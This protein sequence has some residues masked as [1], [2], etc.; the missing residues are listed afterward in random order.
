MRT[1]F[2]LKT[3]EHRASRAE[4]RGPRLPALLA[5]CLFAFPVLA[6]GPQAGASETGSAAVPSAAPGAGNPGAPA[7]EPPRLVEFVEAL[8]PPQA[9]LERR[10]ATVELRL[11]LDAQGAVIAAEVTTPA[12]HGFDEAARE[13][14]LRFRFEPAKRHG[15]AVPS[16]IAYAYAFRLP[17]PASA[18]ETSPSARAPEAALPPARVP[19]TAAEEAIEVTVEG[20]SEAERRRQSAEAVRVIETESLQREAV[21]M[22]QALART[23]GIS[24]RRAGGLGSRAS[25]SLA[26][27]SDEQVRF[28]VDGVPL[29]LA[30]FGPDFANVP[31]N[32]V[33]RLEV[34]TGVVPLRFGAD[35][36]GGAIHLVT[37]DDIRGTHASVSYELGSFETHRLTVSARHLREPQ[38]FFVRA[39]GFF[40]TTPNDYNVDVQVA[41][42]SGRL[43]S[44]RVPRFHD[45][46]RAGGGALEAGFVDRPW[47]RRLLLRAFASTTTKEIQHDT[48]MKVPYGDVDSGN[49]SAGATLRF[50]HTPGSGPRTDAVAGYVFRQ[51]R[52]SDEGRCAYDWFGHC[53]LQLPQPGEI[54]SRAVDRVVNQHTGFARINLG[55]NASTDHAFRIALAPTV[56]DRSGGDKALQASGQFDPLTSRRTVTSLVSGL[57]YELDALD[58]RLENIAFLKDYLQLL[59]ADRLLPD[60]T[61]VP[62]RRDTHELGLGDSLRF[63][64]SPQLSAKASYE[65]ATRLPNPDALFGDGILIGENLELQ[66]ETSHN[67][68][69]ELSAQLP[70][71]TRG[72]FRGSVAGFGRLT[73]QLI[74][75]LGE[76]GYFTYQNVFAARGVGTT[77]AVGWTSPGQYVSLDGNVTWQDLRS[78]SSQGAFGSFEGQR[79]PNRPALLAN[80]SARFLL[81]SIISPRDELS[82]TWRT[83]YVDSFF[84]AWEKLGVT[85]SKQLIASQ[86]L[87]SLALTYVFRGPPTTLSWTVDVENLT[88]ATAF[89]FA[90]VQRAGRSV[91]AKLVLEL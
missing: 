77:G 38:G 75:P 34:Y 63:R 56:V 37:T 13:A 5:G 74:I 50:E 29:E 54:E 79:I 59:R 18:P 82:L 15:T 46:Y 26:G 76:Q 11:T 17:L 69:L 36:L 73:E 81:G 80:A 87:H 51:T 14:A 44:V 60:N 88:D 20:E 85:E 19:E 42:A 49:D 3:N 67:L 62:A 71:A 86:L 33:Q 53:I 65:R 2:T 12:G 28:F 48:T 78:T 45:A 16:R 58:G 41:D 55:W 21:D 43:V 32:L 7:I 70:T 25:L 9:E 90:G 68:N 64:I 84:R 66:P 47:A 91:S 52:F 39:T 4:R 23:E 83:R 40:D 27:L 57:E 89:D 72:T 10:E 24:V 61:F 1:I 30:G 35:A 6:G 31:V 8:Y 22:G